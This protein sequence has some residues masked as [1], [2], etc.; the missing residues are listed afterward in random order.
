MLGV[1]DQEVPA[2]Q[3][4]VLDERWL[5]RADEAPNA[6]SPSASFAFVAFCSM[7]ARRSVDPEAD[8]VLPPLG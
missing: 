3:R 6:G 2:E 7:T 5:G 8:D 1:E 4:D